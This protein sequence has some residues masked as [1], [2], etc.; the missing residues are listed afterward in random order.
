MKLQ[1]NDVAIHGGGRRRGLS[2][3]ARKDDGEVIV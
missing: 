2:R 1:R 3:F